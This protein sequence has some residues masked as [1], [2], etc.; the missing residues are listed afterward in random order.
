MKILRNFSL[1]LYSCDRG[2]F[3]SA[4]TRVLGFL[5]TTRKAPGPICIAVALL[6]SGPIGWTQVTSGDLVGIVLDPTGGAVPGAQVEV[7]EESTGVRASQRTE[8]NGQYRFSNLHIG[9]YDLVVN[10]AGFT[11]A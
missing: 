4:K 7:V 6:A 11:R 9:K 10:A 2:L 8:A 1:E 5:A 3:A